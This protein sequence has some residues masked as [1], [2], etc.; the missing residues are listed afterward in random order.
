ML[1][2][3]ITTTTT[4]T[5]II[6]PQK[7]KILACSMIESQFAYCPLIWMFYLNI[8]T[9]RCNKYKTLHMAYNNCMA[10][11][12]DLLA[13]DNNLKTHQRHLQFLDIEI[14]K[15]KNKPI[16]RGISLSIPNVNTQKYGINS[17]NFRGSV[18]WN[19][20]PI[21]LKNVNFHKNLSYC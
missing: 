17:L 1:I 5:T 3:I 21:K 9:Q 6:Y 20:L 16:R 7:A 10:I 15:S 4:I 11:Y 18:L 8:D 2:I 19:N 14:Y 13:L 12:D